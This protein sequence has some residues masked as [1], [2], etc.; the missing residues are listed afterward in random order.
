MHNHRMQYRMQCKRVL[1]TELHCLSKLV[2]KSLLWGSVT[3]HRPAAL[4]PAANLTSTSAVSHQQHRLLRTEQP[5][6]I[7]SAV[8]LGLTMKV[9]PLTGW[10]VPYCLL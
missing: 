3:T 9:S 5:R 4:H 8:L 6:S 10:M 7:K 1:D 2:V